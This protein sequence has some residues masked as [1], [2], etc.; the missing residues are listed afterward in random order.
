MKVPV[1]GGPAVAIAT[2]QK[3]GGPI[4]VDATSVYWVYASPGAV[5]KATEPHR[6]R[7]GFV[8]VHGSSSHG[9]NKHCETGRLIRA[10]ERSYQ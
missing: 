4:A 5:M 1:G 7:P 6:C 2:G 8:E 9:W 10:A 3:G